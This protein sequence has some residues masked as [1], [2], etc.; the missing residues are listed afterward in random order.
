VGG[1]IAVVQEKQRAGKAKNRQSKE[2]EKIKAGK[3]KSRK[4]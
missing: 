4:G 1:S 2:Q 3:D